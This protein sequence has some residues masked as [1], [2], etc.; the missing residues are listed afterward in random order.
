MQLT[1]QNSPSSGVEAESP[2]DSSDSAQEKMEVDES[3]E[4]PQHNPIFPFFPHPNPAQLLTTLIL[5]ARP[6]Y[7]QMLQE[8]KNND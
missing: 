4:S 2:S 5:F 7:L 6:D 8:K 1:S 3:A